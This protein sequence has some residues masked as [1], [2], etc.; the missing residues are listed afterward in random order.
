MRGEGKVQVSSQRTRALNPRPKGFYLKGGSVLG[1]PRGGSYQNMISFLVCPFRG[2][3]GRSPL[4][5]QHQGRAQESMQLV[6]LSVVAAFLGLELKWNRGLDGLGGVRTSRS[7]GLN[8]DGL[9]SGF[10]VHSPSKGVSSTLRAT[11]LWEEGSGEYPNPTTSEAKVRESNRMTRDVLGRKVRS[12]GEVPVSSGLP[13]A[14]HLGLSV[15]GPL[16][17]LCACLSRCI[18]QNNAWYTNKCHLLYL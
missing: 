11:C 6:L 7:W 4:T 8:A 14:R 13:F 9:L 17:L 5:G 12:G 10:L 1:A 15:P 2:R 18:P 16:S 3:G